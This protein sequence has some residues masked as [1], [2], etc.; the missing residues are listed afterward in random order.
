M[1]EDVNHIY[2]N[3]NRKIKDR[4]TK[5]ERQIEGRTYKF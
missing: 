5:N 4:K 1:F 3:K 2:L